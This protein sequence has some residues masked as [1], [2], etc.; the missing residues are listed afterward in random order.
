[1]LKPNRSSWPQCS[2]P[3]IPVNNSGAF[4]VVSPYAVRLHRDVTQMCSGDELFEIHFAVDSHCSY[5]FCAYQVT[6][7]A[8][9]QIFGALRGQH[10]CNYGGKTRKLCSQRKCGAVC[11]CRV[12]IAFTTTF[13]W[14]SAKG[15]SGVYVSVVQSRCSKHCYRSTRTMC[16]WF[17]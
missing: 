12:E 9:W 2:A 15:F 14:C 16:V 10:M 7:Q 8:N 11:E 17:A 1:M 4:A 5:P 6:P 3:L 13:F